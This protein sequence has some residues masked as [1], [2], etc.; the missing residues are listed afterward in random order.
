MNS[1]DKYAHVDDSEHL[2]VCLSMDDIATNVV[3]M[4]YGTTARTA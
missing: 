3:N 4:N 1:F 2:T